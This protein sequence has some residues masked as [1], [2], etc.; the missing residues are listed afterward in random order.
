LTSVLSDQWQQIASSSWPVAITILCFAVSLKIYRRTNCHP[1]LHPLLLSTILV[2]AVIYLL[3]IDF[4]VYLSGNG[5]LLWL[6]GPATVALAVPLAT[7]LRQLSAVIYPTLSLVLLGGF[8]A[9]LAALVTAP[10]LGI[11]NAMIASIAAKSVT[12]PIAI[13]ITQQLGGLLAVIVP[14]VLITGLVG[15]LFADFIF[16]RFG[17]VDVRWQGLILGICCHAIGTAKAFEKGPLCGSFATLGMGLNGLWTAFFLP[18]IAP[19][20]LS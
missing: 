10:W 17:V 13:G 12:T 6:V 15:I 8:V 9:T 7:Q 3:E 14:T 20:F 18:L 2:T 5:I 19:F 16:T 1:L 4:T 11:S